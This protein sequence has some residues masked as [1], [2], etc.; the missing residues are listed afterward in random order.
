[1]PKTLWQVRND[2]HD[3]RRDGSR[4][5]RG[6]STGYGDRVSDATI[7]EHVSEDVA[8]RDTDSLIFRAAVLR[9]RTHEREL[10]EHQAIL[11]SI[12]E[13]EDDETW[14]ARALVRQGENRPAR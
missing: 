7:W 9:L 13:I 2:P 5:R 3:V 11:D 4:I 10:A 14:R 12:D 8:R 1:M 6:D